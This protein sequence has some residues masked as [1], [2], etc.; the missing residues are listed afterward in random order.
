MSG[1]KVTTVDICNHVFLSH[2]CRDEN[3]IYD[4]AV[5]KKHYILMYR[6]HATLLFMSTFPY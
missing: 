3:C 6:T 4:S 1:N 5:S 2:H